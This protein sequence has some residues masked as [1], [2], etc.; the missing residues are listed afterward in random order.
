MGGGRAVLLGGGR[1]GVWLVGGGLLLQ[2]HSQIAGWPLQE[3]AQEA[4]PDQALGG[5]L[6]L[7]ASKQW[8]WFLHLTSTCHQANSHRGQGR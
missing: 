5:L 7:P 8:V 2:A 4:R 1:A 3:R 6:A